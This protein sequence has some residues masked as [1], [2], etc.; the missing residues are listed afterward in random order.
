MRIGRND[1]CPCGSGNKYKKCCLDKGD[2]GS[3]PWPVFP[4][5]FA[6]GRLREESQRFADFYTAERPKIGTRV[7]WAKDEKLPEGIWG[8]SSWLDTG[9]AVVRQAS[10]PVPVDRDYAVAHELEHL[11]LG[12]EGFPLTGSARKNEDISSALN[13]MLHDPLVHERLEAYAFRDD[14]ASEYEDDSSEARRQLK[15]LAGPVNRTQ[16]IRWA[17]NYAGN[18]F[19]WRQLNGTESDPSEFQKWFSARF[20][21]IASDAQDLVA[22]V[23]RIG[24][25]TPERMR[26]ALL[27]ILERYTL[28]D[29]VL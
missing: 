27:A 16:S 10:I 1:S 17:L 23:D 21:A 9:E 4:E 6:I 15:N 2:E 3:L 18:L 11:V 22:M 12:A 29:L 8:R 5:D 13:S 7:Y 28:R 19:D 20:P 24:Y 26:V 25:D 14:I